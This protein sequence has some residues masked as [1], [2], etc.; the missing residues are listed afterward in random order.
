MSDLIAVDI[1]EIIGVN[2]DGTISA[3][4]PS[5]YYLKRARYP[6]IVVSEGYLNDPIRFK[7]DPKFRSYTSISQSLPPSGTDV[8][9]RD[10]A[11]FLTIDRNKETPQVFIVNMISPHWRRES[12]EKVIGPRAK[13]TQFGVTL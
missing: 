4:D 9:Q 11:E 5:D 2:P 3:Q 6:N 7:V 12:Y 10:F 1:I 8:I 13:F